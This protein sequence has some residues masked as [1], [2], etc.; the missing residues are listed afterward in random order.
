[1]RSFAFL[2]AFLA[3]TATYAD[4]QPPK[5]ADDQVE[6]DRAKLALELCRTAAKEYRLCLADSKST[7]LEL[8]P[9]PVLRWSNPS[10]GSIHGGVFLWTH[11]GRPAAVASIF[12]WFDP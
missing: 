6:K 5:A 1:M 2:C 12:K 4:D 8:K 10:V 9:E 11:K 7:E 3:A